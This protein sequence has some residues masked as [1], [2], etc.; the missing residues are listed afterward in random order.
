MKFITFV[1]LSISLSAAINLE[2]SVTDKTPEGFKAA[3]L[4]QPTGDNAHMAHEYE[5]IEKAK[6]HSDRV[7]GSANESHNATEWLPWPLGT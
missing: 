4:P 2:R 5:R 1:A 3:N 7:I 6:K